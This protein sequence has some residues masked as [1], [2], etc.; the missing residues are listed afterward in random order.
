LEGQGLGD[1]YK[2]KKRARNRERKRRV[3][4]GT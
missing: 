2:K 1:E 3:E 4:E